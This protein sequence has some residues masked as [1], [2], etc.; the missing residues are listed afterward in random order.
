MDGCVGDEL[1]KEK[2]RVYS[3]P[4]ACI[5]LEFE[6]VCCKVALHHVLAYL[7]SWAS[8]AESKPAV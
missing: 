6:Q 1:R 5:A 7:R 8:K 3:T 2:S 4:N